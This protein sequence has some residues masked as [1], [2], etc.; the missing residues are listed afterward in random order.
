MSRG[1]GA[2]QPTVIGALESAAGPLTLEE[3]CLAVYP[4]IAR[5]GRT[6]KSSIG[7]ALNIALTVLFGSAA[8]LDTIAAFGGCA[9]QRRSRS[10]CR[11][12]L[13]LPM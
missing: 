2:V 8:S 10:P 6:H 1:H 3:L 9:G 7:R 4:G 13:C 11:L 5:A 12:A